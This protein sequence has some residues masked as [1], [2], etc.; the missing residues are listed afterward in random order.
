MKTPIFIYAEDAYLIGFSTLD[1]A[2][3]SLEAIDV[4]DNLYK[5]FDAEGRLLNIEPCESIARITEAESEPTHQLE[6][7]DL[8]KKEMRKKPIIPGDDLP[9]LIAQRLKFGLK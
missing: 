8:L 4:E 9:S 6:L 3:K 5:G 7:I 2:E 1:E